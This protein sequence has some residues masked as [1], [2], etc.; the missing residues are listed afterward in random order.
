MANNPKDL[1]LPPNIVKTKKGNVTAVTGSTTPSFS[2]KSWL[3]F[4]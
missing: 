4:W 1:Y 3:N 2:L